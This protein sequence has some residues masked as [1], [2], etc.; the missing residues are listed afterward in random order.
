MSR[1]LSQSLQKISLELGPFPSLKL[2][3]WGERRFCPK[4]RKGEEAL[5]EIIG[6]SLIEGRWSIL[7][8]FF[9]NLPLGS[10]RKI[11]LQQFETWTT[12]FCKVS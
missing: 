8:T 1:R 3:A 5:K 6:V 4:A 10:R 2:V 9:L 11:D 12:T 7:P